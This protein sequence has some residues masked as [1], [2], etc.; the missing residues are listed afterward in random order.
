VHKAPFLELARPSLASDGL[1]SL[2]VLPPSRPLVDWRC[3]RPPVTV[4]RYGGESERFDLVRCDGSMAPG[5]LDA[6]SILARPPE[7]LRPAD[8]LPDEPDQ[9]AWRTRREWVDG[10]RVVHP[11][12][13]WAVQRIADAFPGKTIYLYSG[14][15]PLA[16]VNDGSGHKSTHAEGRA[17]DIA[18]MRVPNEKLF[19]V[20]RELKDVACGFYPKSKFVHIGVRRAHT[21]KAM[22]IDASLPGEPAEYVDSWP[23]V[24]E[25][26]AL[27]WQKA[28]EPSSR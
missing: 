7:T 21:G 26:G 16:E 6:L 8:G 4:V 1:G 22:W 14:Y 17:L 11:R 25:K 10:V 23:G 15:R 20:C 3:R 12:L 5:A 13:V 18:V 2:F 19:E 9:D 28:P 27:S 24:V